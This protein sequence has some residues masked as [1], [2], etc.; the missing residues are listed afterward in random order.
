MSKPGEDVDPTARTE[1]VA[2]PLPEVGHEDRLVQG[3][4]I[5]GWVVGRQ[6]GKGGFGLVYR[7]HRESDGFIA[8]LKILRLSFA[9]LGWAIERFL[10]EVQAMRMVK[11]PGLVEIHH[12]GRLPDGRPFYTMDLVEGSDLLS[13]LRP[14]EHLSPADANHILAQVCA[15]LEAAH[16]A[17]VIHRDIK[18]ANIL[19]TADRTV[20]LVDFGIAKLLEREGPQLTATGQIIGSSTAMSPEQL[21]CGTIDRRT[22]VYALGALAFRL[23]TGS[24]LFLGDPMVVAAQH[25]EA[26]APAPSK[27]VPV[28]PALDR[29]VLRCLE[30]NPAARWQTAAEFAEAFRAV[31]VGQA[32]GGGARRGVAILVRTTPRTDDDAALEASTAAVDLAEAELVAAGFRIALQTSSE[33]LGVR[34]GDANAVRAEAVDLA[35]RLA[36]RLSREHQGAR[37]G[38]AVHADDVELSPSGVAV[39][40][41]LLDV[42]TWG[43]VEEG[44]M[45][46]G[47]VER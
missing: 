41:P 16:A 20:K 15:A 3:Q 23:L 1:V 9:K 12:V 45:V 22:D 14:G 28:S 47:G 33:V 43:H 42:D 24:N 27:L 10:R 11:H 19:M 17:G 25:L 26:P 21:L 30:K 6:L 40:G 8:A 31:A 46:M 35:R 39:G 2:L 29:V 5:D 7:A 37:T 34:E 38:I 44:V 13:T 18:P 32:E 4:V 36:E